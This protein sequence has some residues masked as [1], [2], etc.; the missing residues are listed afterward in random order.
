[1][2]L[3]LRTY[4]KKLAEQHNRCFYCGELLAS[5]KI[6]IDHIIPVTLNGSGQNKNLCLACYPC[7]RL[8]S[9]KSLDEFKRHLME[10]Y[11]S[12]LVRGMF[13]FEF[14]NIYPNA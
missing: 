5:G 3:P 7:N 4:N 13:F 2:K 9:N 1:M 14:I 10:M 11:P 12:K 8:K 6:E